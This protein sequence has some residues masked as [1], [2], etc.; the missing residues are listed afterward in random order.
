M[1]DK[2]AGPFRIDS[3][4]NFGGM[5]VVTI[6]DAAGGAFCFVAPSDCAG[7]DMSAAKARGT[8]IAEALARADPPSVTASSSA[9]RDGLGRITRSIVIDDLTPA[10]IAQLFAGQDSGGQAEFFTEL[11]KITAGWP[12]AG[13]CMQCA[14]I[15]DLMTPEGRQIVTTLAEHIGAQS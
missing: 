15:K 8:R 3:D 9:G 6:L 11:A 10:E 4:S 1:T 5:P 7:G 12:G 2:G 14:H 13:W